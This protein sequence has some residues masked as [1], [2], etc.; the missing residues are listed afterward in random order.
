M[1]WVGT[2][3]EW[4]EWQSQEPDVAQV[5]KWV[6]FGI[7]PTP[8]GKKTVSGCLLEDW[9]DLKVVWRVLQKNG[10]ERWRVVVAAIKRREVWKVYHEALGHAQG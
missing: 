4:A 2:Y 9:E 8:E 6:Q 1:A 3:K 10:E 7:N 5:C